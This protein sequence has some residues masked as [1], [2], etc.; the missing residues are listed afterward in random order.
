MHECIFLLVPK[1]I[2][3]DHVAENTDDND[4][5]IKYDRPD[6]RLLAEE[7]NPLILLLLLRKSNQDGCDAEKQCNHRTRPIGAESIRLVRSSEQFI[8]DRMEADDEKKYAEHQ[9]RPADCFPTKRKHFYR[10]HTMK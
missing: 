8:R 3:Q 9:H 7:G 4:D 5:D 2:I 6:Q 10:F 1:Q